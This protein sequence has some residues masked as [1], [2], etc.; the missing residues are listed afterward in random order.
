[1][2]DFDE[3]EN[4]HSIYSKVIHHEWGVILFGRLVVFIW[5]SINEVVR[6]EMD[7]IW[8]AEGSDTPNQNAYNSKRQEASNVEPPYG[9]NFLGEKVD[10]KNTMTLV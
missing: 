10:R 6:R 3:P 9:T 2:V 1:M 4:E 7:A 8:D 5:R